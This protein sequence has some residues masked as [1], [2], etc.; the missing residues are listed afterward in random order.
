LEATH[1]DVRYAVEGPS[2][3]VIDAI[4]RTLPETKRRLLSKYVKLAE[5]WLADEDRL[6][7]ERP[8]D[9]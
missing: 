9:T 7:A 8:S 4:Q 2:G 3:G 6:K 1:D 5:T